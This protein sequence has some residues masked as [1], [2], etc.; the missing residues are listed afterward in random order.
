EPMGASAATETP[1]QPE[2]ELFL[3]PVAYK[4]PFEEAFTQLARAIRLGVVGVGE[5]FP[6]ERVLSERLGVSRTTVREAIRGLEQSGYITTRR[7]RYGGT[8]VLRD[9]PLL[10]VKKNGRGK[11]GPELV[12]V[13][14]FRGAIEPGA[15][16]L[17]ARKAEGDQAERM[18]EM[19]AAMKAGGPDTF[20]RDNC[21]LHIMFAQAAACEPLLA[22]VTT[23][24]LEIMDAFVETPEL[25]PSE[26]RSHTQHQE[27][28]EA[29]AA[30][31]AD[32]ARAAM[33][34]HLGG[35]D[36]IMRE[37]ATPKRR[38]RR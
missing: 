16:A 27:I 6:P 14:D 21:R 37:L 32:G 2:P 10:P 25:N 9:E 18:R 11:I 7:G 29:I 23:V 5:K 24:E 12:E 4:N 15:V 36:I 20:L 13:L 17:A 8:F 26:A 35:T 1:G 28:V 33:E 38:R 31:D 30:G 19:V 34:A 3:Q 22:A